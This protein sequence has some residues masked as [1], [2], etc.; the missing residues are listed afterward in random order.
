MVRVA[1]VLIVGG[2][3]VFGRLLAV[4][5]LRTTEAQIVIAG[6]DPA[7][8]RRACRDLSGSPQGRLESMTIDLARSGELR[9]T[10]EDFDVVAC[11]AGPFQALSPWIVDEAVEAGAH[12]VDVADVSGWVLGV[13]E[14]RELDERARTADVAIGTGLSTLPALS[15]VLARLLTERVPQASTATVVLSIGNRNQKGSATIASALMND[16]RERSTVH[17]PLGPR[18]AYRIDSPDARLFDREHLDT[19]SWVAL[20]SAIARR[21][22]V[23]AAGRSASRDPG[24]VM[25]RARFLSRVASVWRSGA[26]GGS[27]QVELRDERGSGAA[28]AFVG[29]DQ[30]MA[31]LPAAIVVQRLVEGSVSLRGI[32]PPA[33]WM[34]IP[35]WIA[36]LRG[37]G[38]GVLWRTIR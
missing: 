36:E 24:E 38:V 34:P 5:L 1:R 18:L 13:L 9:R 26:S 27:V 31:I 10:A 33:D 23:L 11:T 30:R 25:G 21:V 6:R 2:Y 32:T 29:L 37:R 8:A 3:G 16:M 15:G 12:W 14:D 22:A 7:K 35:E 19:T 28:A 20:E 4:E 17:T